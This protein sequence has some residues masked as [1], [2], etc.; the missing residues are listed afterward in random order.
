MY[1]VVH[2]VPLPRLGSFRFHILET[3]LARQRAEKVA[4]AKLLVGLVGPQ[5]GLEEDALRVLLTSY[6]ETI[7]QVTY[8]YKYKSAQRRVFEK[9]LSRHEEDAR[10]LDKVKA[11]TVPGRF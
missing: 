9:Q 4:F 5:S 2:G 1:C 7:Y 10:L 8:N 3:G 11:M 6:A